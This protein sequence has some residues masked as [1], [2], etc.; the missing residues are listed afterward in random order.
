MGFEKALALSLKNLLSRV[1]QA[2]MTRGVA[3]FRT[4]DE[5]AGGLMML[6][7]PLL[8]VL[9]IQGAAVAMLPASDTLLVAAG[10][11]DAALEHM[12][13]L[14]EHT[15][16][17]SP[18]W[19]SLRAMSD[20]ER[21]P[22]KADWLPPTGHALHT[23]FLAAANTTRAREVTAIHMQTGLDQRA[24]L[25]HLAVRAPHHGGQLVASWFRGSSVAIPACAQRVVLLDTPDSG[26]PLVEV[27]LPTL[28][29]V[30]PASFEPL[31][32][33]SNA[34]GDPVFWRARPTGFPSPRVLAHLREAVKHQ[35]AHPETQPRAVEAEEI[36]HAWDAGE[37]VT[38]DVTGEDELKLMTPD[39]RHATVPASVMANRIAALPATDHAQ[40]LLGWMALK[41]MIEQPYDHLIAQLHPLLE[42]DKAG[43]TQLL[44]AS[45]NAVQDETELTEVAPP[46]PRQAGPVGA[47][48]NRRFEP[49]ALFPVLRPPQYAQASQQST[50]GMVPTHKV[51]PR[52]NR[53][54]RPLLEGVTVEVVADM[55][56]VMLT[57]DDPGLPEVW[58]EGAR[59]TAMLNL[60]A[61]S[62]GDFKPLQPGAY[63]APWADGYAASR[64]LLPSLFANLEVH[65]DVLLV[66]PT[67][68][69]L[70]VTG[71][72][73]TEGLR[74]VV[75]AV[76]EHLASGTATTAYAW[77]ECLFGRPWVLRDGQLSLWKVPDGHPLSGRISALDDAI[78]K[79]REQS[80]ANAYSHS[81]KLGYSVLGGEKQ[82]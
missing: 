76:E 15:F 9:P 5:T 35:Q 8:R 7:E 27:D 66:T 62:Q 47:R 12:L 59:N 44:L 19:C 22:S 30:T 36:L 11:D 75:H 18:R 52:L 26:F 49:M 57:L 61:A 21:L 23:R 38:V 54:T 43:R 51:E 45:S 74:A 64:I 72:Q 16:A 34:S 77:R 17:V 78:T 55:G 28:L 79:R 14:A 1:R 33:D 37:P 63:R 24:P 80:G 39:Q 41:A 58:L 73:D 31:H 67:V 32:T 53:T 2:E 40:V 13:D 82:Q 50:A 71:T 6:M 68:S 3:M 29:N 69:T 20:L 46:G 48:M 81:R 56:D 25:A 60:A 70:W 10:N 42:E 4:P 65:G